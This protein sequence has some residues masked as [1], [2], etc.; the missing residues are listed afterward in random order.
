[1]G[2]GDVPEKCFSEMSFI[3]RDTTV[4]VCAVREA[5]KM[6]MYVVLFS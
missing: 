2:E 6:R 4:A 3:A 1:M 5:T